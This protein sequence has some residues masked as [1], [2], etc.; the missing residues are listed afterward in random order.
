[1]SLNNLKQKALSNPQ[2]HDEYQSLES[3]FSFIDQLLSMRTEAG[4]T[5][6]Q[7]AERMHTQKSNISRLER[8][9]ANPSWLT[10]LKYADACG[11]ELSLGVR[12]R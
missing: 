12:K 7:V 8:G 1:M 6:E 3:E 4:L 10:L 2:V 9:N 11:F 5:Q